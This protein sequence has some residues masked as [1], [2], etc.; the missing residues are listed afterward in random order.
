M[1][2][3]QLI[4]NLGPAFVE[5]WDYWSSL[6]KTD[7]IPQFADYVDNVPPHLQPKVSMMDTMSPTHMRVRHMG[8]EVVQVT[9]E[10]T[11]SDGQELYNKAII[12]KAAKTVWT[13]AAFPCGYIIPRVLSTKNGLQVDM[14]GLV[15]PLATKTAGCKTVVAYNHISEK[16][17][18]VKIDKGLK[19]VQGYGDVTWV[20]IGAGV[21]S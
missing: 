5:F 6:P 21:P 15:L 3:I 12:E 8:T 11:G 9:G 18:S 4:E 1:D 14:T 2:Q 20:D 13:A 16:T 10:F 7:H 17:K 19:T